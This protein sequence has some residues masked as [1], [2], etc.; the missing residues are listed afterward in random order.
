[1]LLENATIRNI[2]IIIKDVATR[3]MRVQNSKNI[4]ATLNYFIKFWLWS[5]EL[6][7]FLKSGTFYSMCLSLDASSKFFFS[8]LRGKYFS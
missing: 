5:Y 2:A 1:M 8:M 6:D 7:L 3:T 4:L